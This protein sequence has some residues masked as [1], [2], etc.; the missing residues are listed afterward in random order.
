VL[1]G[2][3]VRNRAPE[4]L[5]GSPALLIHKAAEERQSAMSTV[6]AVSYSF[7]KPIT[8]P[9]PEDARKAG[10]ITIDGRVFL[11]LAKVRELLTI[12]GRTPSKDTVQLWAKSECV[13]I[14]RMIE[15]E[16]LPGPAG[17][18]ESWYLEE[19]IL[20]IK[21]ALELEAEADGEYI[22]P[23]GRCICAAEVTKRYG[24]D[25][26]TLDSWAVGCPHRRSGEP[27]TLTVIK[28]P[29]D[30]R[31]WY[32][33]SELDEI[34][35]T[36][37]NRYE[38]TKPGEARRFKGTY[39]TADGQDVIALRLAA[40]QY[41]IPLP[42]LKIYIQER[43]CPYFPGG[44]LPCQWVDP[45]HPG[46]KV[47]V[48]LPS[49]MARLKAAINKAV[50]DGKRV[51]TERWMD[52]QEIGRHYDVTSID[53][54]KLLCEMVRT[55][56]QNKELP[57]RRIVRE[58]PGRRGRRKRVW[59]HD[60]TVLDQLLRREEEVPSLGSDK[61]P[62]SPEPPV[63]AEEAPTPHESD[64]PST[65]TGRP[66]SDLTMEVQAFCYEQHQGPAQQKLPAIRLAAMR[67]FGIDRAPKEDAHVTLYAKRYSQKTGLPWKSRS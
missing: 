40:R 37:A 4:A 1:G 52:Y 15:R 62:S 35:Q 18:K 34:K 55:M 11:I 22:A 26:K 16:K 44:Q 2:G 39:K 32:L 63:V 23:E 13:H 10:R 25:H 64:R 49:D 3:R 21:R 59:V 48:V 33:I 57:A 6:E 51:N 7:R 53:D 43:K 66:R 19:D 47:P 27:A 31:K 60:V 30:R 41:A 56:R 24:W 45:S 12:Q 50:S 61:Q 17:G 5:P 36:L 29:N 38:K 20:A 42:T 14:G 46:P 9:V 67:L 65:R 8:R 54:Y 58:H 28:R